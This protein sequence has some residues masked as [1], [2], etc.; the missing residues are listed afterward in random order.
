[1]QVGS[2]LVGID[3][4]VCFAVPFLLFSSTFFCSAVKN[5]N[6][7]DSHLLMFRFP[8]LVEEP[9]VSLSMR[10]ICELL[11]QSV[12]G[13]SC[14]QYLKD[15][16]VKLFA[17]FTGMVPEDYLG[18]EPW[19]FLLKVIFC[20]RLLMDVNW[21]LLIKAWPTERG[22]PLPVAAI[23][24]LFANI[25][26]AENPTELEVRS[27]TAFLPQASRRIDLIL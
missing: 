7:C 24:D 8:L 19:Q 11:L 14:R 5:M 4:A 3:A 20:V 13:F 9:L 18:H 25:Y 6:F 27:R 2:L 15:P 21:K 23:M 17:M 12:H 22:A 26:N 1:M 16:Q 10:W